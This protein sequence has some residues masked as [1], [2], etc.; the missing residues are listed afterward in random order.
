[1][2]FAPRNHEQPQPLLTSPPAR[3]GLQTR[4]ILRQPPFKRLQVWKRKIQELCLNENSG[5][6]SATDLVH[7]PLRQIWRFGGTV[8][9]NI[10]IFT[11]WVCTI[12]IL[13]RCGTSASC[14]KSTP[15]PFKLHIQMWNKSTTEPSRMLSVV[16]ASANFSGLNRTPL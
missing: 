1:M 6:I 16:R 5:F 13:F 15:G 10:V 2:T 4:D 12:I 7:S 9:I 14:Y 11:A 3:S 8:M